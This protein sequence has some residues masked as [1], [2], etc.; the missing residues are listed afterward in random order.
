M[1]REEEATAV[2]TVACLYTTILLQHASAGATRLCV[3]VSILVSILALR[4]QL[5]SAQGATA[6]VGTRLCWQY[7]ASAT[8]QQI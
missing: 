7:G 8:K 1:W 6:A 5:T 3:L 2:N 4:K